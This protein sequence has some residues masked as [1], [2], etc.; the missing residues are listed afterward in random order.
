VSDRAYEMAVRRIG[1]EV[2]VE[3][4]GLLGYY[5]L[6]SMTINAFRVPVPQG[7]REPF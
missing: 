7:A 6:I 3:L 2:V 4:V 1:L 5:T